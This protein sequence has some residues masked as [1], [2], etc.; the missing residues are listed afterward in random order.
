MR[1]GIVRQ[2]YTDYGGAERFIGAL[3]NGLSQWPLE[4][5]LLCRSWSGSAPA[6]MRLENIDPFYVTR[7]WRDRSFCSAIQGVI[8]RRRFD[9]LQ[10]HERIPGCD[11]Y[12]AGDGTHRGWLQHRARWRGQSMRWAMLDPYHRYTLRAEEAMFNHPALRAVICNS[13]LIRDE[14][15][16]LYGVPLER[17][18][19]VQ[20]AVDTDRFKPANAEERAALR[21]REGVTEQQGVVLFVG[22]GY[23]RKGLGALLQSLP[24]SLHLWVIGKDSQQKKYRDMARA[25]GIETRVRFYGPRTDVAAFYGMAD[26]FVFPAIY[27]PF[28][29]VV[30]EA[31]ASGIPALTSWQCGAEQFVQQGVNGWMVDAFDVPSLQR[32]MESLVEDLG[33]P[34][35]RARMGAAARHTAEQ[36]TRE[37]M[38]EQLIGLYGALL[39]PRQG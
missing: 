29:N 16:R 31:L 2:R 17:L 28:G 22:S 27:E 14:I 15:H 37:R 24:K 8:A 39:A 7:L 18:T 11:V 33:D 38:M 3:L 26:A 23:E 32:A 9:L 10:S 20:N 13:R 36:F 25:Q 19:L 6:N 4:V 34:L 5:T 21:A 35:K 1:L 30:L 12:R